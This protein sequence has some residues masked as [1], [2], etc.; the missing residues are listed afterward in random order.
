MSSM[1]ISTLSFGITSGS[2]LEL[3]VGLSEE[4]LL[5]V[6]LELLLFALLEFLLV[7][8]LEFLFAVPELL[9]VTLLEVVPEFLL[10]VELEPVFELS[11]TLLEVVLFLSLLSVL[12]SSTKFPLEVLS[13]E[14]SST[15]VALLFSTVFTL[16]EQLQEVE[17]EI[18][19]ILI[20]AKNIYFFIF[21]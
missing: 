7:V 2:L 3:F 11:V 9:F 5:V 1:L 19:K 21:I 15:T 17:K 8:L 20:I 16:D 12:L 14:L 13:C 10:T 6:L 18:I 4:V